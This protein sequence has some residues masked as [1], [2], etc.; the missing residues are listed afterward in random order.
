MLVTTAIDSS[1]PT[2]TVLSLVTSTP[3]SRQDSTGE[4]HVAMKEK[5]IE[6]VFIINRQCSYLS[7][8]DVSKRFQG[9]IID[10]LR[11]Q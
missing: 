10:I 9:D 11:S 8:Q 4:A 1:I 6:E 3:P 2:G 7:F 5:A